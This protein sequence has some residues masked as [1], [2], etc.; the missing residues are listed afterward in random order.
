VL[1]PKIEEF[2]TQ[3]KDDK[4]TIE[5]G[6]ARLAGII[7]IRYGAPPPQKQPAQPQGGGIE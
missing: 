2:L 6:F 5:E 1:Y 3:N 7:G 4:T